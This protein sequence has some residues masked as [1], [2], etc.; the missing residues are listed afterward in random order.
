VNKP[1]G[2]YL[3]Q[4]DLALTNGIDRIHRAKG[5]TRLHWQALNHIQENGPIAQ[6]QLAKTLQPFTEPTNLGQILEDLKQRAWVEQTS[7]NRLCLTTA[8]IQEH[9]EMLEA[10]QAFRVQFMQ[11]ISQE[12]Y[13]AVLRVLQ[14]MLD[15]LSA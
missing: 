11:G 2:Y 14:K 13:T 4:T 3:R 10:Q 8:G 1:I 5:L 9:A 15:N 12:E 7:G 6:A